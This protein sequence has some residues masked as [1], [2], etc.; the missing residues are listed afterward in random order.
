MKTKKVKSSFMI[1]VFLHKMLI[2]LQMEF[3]RQSFSNQA[4][5]HY[6]R[7]IKMKVEMIELLLAQMNQK[8]KT[9]MIIILT[10]NKGIGYSIQGKMLNL[11]MKVSS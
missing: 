7:K 3:S 2:L 10:K 1:G 6:L 11:I 5:S 9:K 8:I 4:K